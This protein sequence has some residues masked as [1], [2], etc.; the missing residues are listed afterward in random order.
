MII[1]QL[2]VK[3]THEENNKTII[4]HT[5]FLQQHPPV[6]IIQKGKERALFLF[7]RYYHK[8]KN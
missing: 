1:K 6:F 3:K 4:L 2:K 8:V 7:L 5:H